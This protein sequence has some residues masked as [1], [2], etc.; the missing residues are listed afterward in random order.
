MT[1]VALGLAAEAVPAWGI[2]RM[3]SGTF[4]WPPNLVLALI[5]ALYLGGVYRIGRGQPDGRWPYRR[6]VAFLAGALAVVVAID[7]G[8]GV[9][10]DVLFADHMAQHLVLIMV[11]APL[12]AMGAPVE[13]AR[14]STTGVL[15]HL[16][17]RS[18]R[19]RIAEVV[20]HPIFDFALYAAMI[21]VAHLTRF[22]DVTLTNT[23]VHDSEHAVFVLIGYLFWR[24]VVAVQPSRHPL[25]RAFGFSTCS[26]HCPS[27][28]SPVLPS[29][30][31]PTSS[32]PSICPS[33]GTGGRPGL[34]TFT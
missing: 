32:S 24:P 31:P 15:H 33:T 11:A 13:L 21:P 27:T 22:Y 7:S 18:L 26:W 1:L 29:H 10:D 5:V 19:S 25:S 9:Y 2:E 12:F 17:V 23:P 34:P 28:H 8:L 4:E 20:G 14:R 16:V 30:P 3:F 6:S